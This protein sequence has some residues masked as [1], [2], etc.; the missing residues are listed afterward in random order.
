MKRS[1]RASSRSLSSIQWTLLLLFL[2]ILAL[3]AL[4]A[5]SW[6][7]RPAVAPIVNAPVTSTATS[8]STPTLTSTPRPTST[9][10]TV[11]PPT[12]PPSPTLA[13]FTPAF[14]ISD[15]RFTLPRGA[16]ITCG[17]VPVPE[18]REIY[19]GRTVRLE[20]A[21]F[22]SSNRS[23]S[24]DPVLY[25]HD[26]P[27]GSAIQWAAVNYDNFVI[28]ITEARDLVV[29]DQRGSGLTLPNLDCPEVKTVQRLDQ[30][31]SLAEDRKSSSYSAALSACRERLASYG[32]DT[33]KYTTNASAADAHDVILAL[34]LEKVNLFGVS[35][36]SRIAQAILRDYPLEIRSAVFDSPL[37]L[38]INLFKE[39]T[40]NHDQALNALFAN[41]ASNT[42]CN[43]TYPDLASAYDNLLV[44][45]DE[46]PIQITVRGDPGTPDF[47]AWLDGQ[48]LT[49][50][51]IKSLNSSFYISSLP[52]I[53]TGFNGTERETSLAYI[54]DAITLEH[55][56]LLDLS[57]GMRFSADCHEQVYAT[58]PQELEE[59]QLSFPRTSFIGMQSILGSSDTLTSLCNT[60]GAA[61]FE[62]GTNQPVQTDIPVLVL[63][64]QF[65]P[66]YTP[67]QAKELAE[68]LS[69]GTFLE[70]PGLG[71]APSFDR[72]STCAINLVA[73]F[74]DNPEQ[75]LDLTCLESLAVPYYTTYTGD[76]PLELVPV[77][78]EGI[79]LQYVVPTGWL[80][81]GEEIYRREAYYG[82]FT[83]LHIQISDTSAT[84]LLASLTNGF[85]GTGFDRT[86]AR[87]TTRYA[88][89]LNWS[90]YR[91][92]LQNRPVELAISETEEQTIW[93]L[94]LSQTSER[95]A[96]YRTVFLPAIDG[97]SLK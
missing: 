76:P 20:V 17:V 62:P 95:D 4:I 23:P 28:P 44:E 11:V 21:I 66:L 78:K 15:C 42:V 29:F 37:P 58:N 77:L 36:G 56:P 6:I 32:I 34:G 3:L 16:S 13:V 65:D 1:R 73:E 79:G 71:H 67:N 54:Q 27:I 35:Y 59:A 26:G 94:L 31:G 39:V 41:C 90:L 80:N 88:N 12:L 74:L 86:P 92:F 85:Q 83:E 10:A 5:L 84:E 24:E 57:A 63:A 68:K 89:R 19:P 18:N 96:L 87:N 91:A 72:R 8:T 25:L 2:I 93:I 75:V 82:D 9:R 14:T 43:S 49:R 38:D 7:N 55:Q 61:P 81:R 60:W 52:R 97:T 46:E 51:L 50:T 40:A 69:N 47:D 70:I 30:R 33:S 64:G 53:I 48:T 22:H 45:L